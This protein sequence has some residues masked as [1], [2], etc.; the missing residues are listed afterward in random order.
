[1]GA[2]AIAAAKHATDEHSPSKKAF[3]I[4][5]FVGE[6]MANGVTESTK[7]VS[8]SATRMGN[9]A[10]GSLTDAMGTTSGQSIG[11]KISPVFDMSS[12]KTGTRAISNAM[13]NSG[14]SLLNGHISVPNVE[15]KD[16]R[17]TAL[18]Q[19]QNQMVQTNAKTI[20]KLDMLS[21]DL[22]AYHQSL[23]EQELAMYVDGKK[24]ASTTAKYTNQ[25]LGKLQ[26]RGQLNR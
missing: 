24:L 13:A 15:Y 8:D 4:G 16:P 21:S 26:R 11:P 12:L 23:S 6:G 9:T 1:M 14:V 18:A 17:V 22:K 10:L 19:Y 3:K 5:H 20:D 25:E 7:L 2:E